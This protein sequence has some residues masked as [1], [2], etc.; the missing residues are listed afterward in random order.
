MKGEEKG[1][2]RGGRG[3]GRREGATLPIFWPRIAQAG[4][5]TLI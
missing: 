2:W 5:I 4:V 1:K 3:E